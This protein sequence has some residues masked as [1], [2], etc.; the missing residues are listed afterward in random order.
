MPALLPVPSVVRHTLV[1]QLDEDIDVINRFFNKYSGSP[2]T[3]NSADATTWAGVVG[4]AW[5][6]HM[7]PNHSSHLT[8]IEVITEDLSSATGAVGAHAVGTVGGASGAWL[9]AGTALVV[10]EKIERRYRGGH[11]RQYLAGI[12][13]AE[14][15]DAQSWLPA[16]L[17]SI[18]PAY[19]AFRAECLTGA[20][21]A[22]QPATD[23]SISYFSGFTNHTFPSGRV[24]PIPNP[25]ATP[26]VDQIATFTMNPK[27]AS[28]RRRNKQSL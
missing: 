4:S 10:S 5:A 15:F 16:Y 7:A 28:Q 26:L 1:Q 9:G 24:R 17:A 11:P 6:T 21:T 2:G 19:I 3:L 12:P 8:L 18:G 25:R 13:S 23:V 14:L 20:P 22:L 27:V